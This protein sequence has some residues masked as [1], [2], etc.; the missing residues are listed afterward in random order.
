MKKKI[1][2]DFIK[3]GSVLLSHVLRHSII[4]AEDFRFPVR[5][6]MERFI[7]RYDHQAKQ[8]QFDFQTTFIFQASGAYD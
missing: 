2:T 5:D 7:P 6:G 4:T 3:P 8:N 1:K